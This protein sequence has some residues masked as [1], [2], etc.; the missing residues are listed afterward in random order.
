V[1]RLKKALKGLERKD[2][3]KAENYARKVLAIDMENE[4]AKYILEQ[5]P[6]EKEAYREEQEKNRTEEEKQKILTEKEKE[7]RKRIKRNPEEAGRGRACQE[8]SRNRGEACG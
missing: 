6:S 2:F 5:L 1:L 3:N 8:T 7:E 4:S